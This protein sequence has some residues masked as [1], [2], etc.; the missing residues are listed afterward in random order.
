[1]LG[2]LLIPVG[3]LISLVSFRKTK[4]KW[5]HCSTRGIIQFNWLIMMAPN[6]VIDYLVAHEVSHLVHMNHSTDYWRVVSSLCPNY[7]IHRDWLR[8]NEHR[9]RLLSE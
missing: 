6:E 5:G 7:K 2:L 3:L 1:M 4:T 9:F 8:E